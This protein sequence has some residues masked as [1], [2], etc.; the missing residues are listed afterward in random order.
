MIDSILK[1]S[2][3]AKPPTVFHIITGVEVGG[4][5]RMLLR[6]MEHFHKGKFKHIVISLLPP[7]S[8]WHD[9]KD[10][11]I[12]M[13]SLGMKGHFDLLALMRYLIFLMRNKPAIV[14]AYLFHALTFA[15]IGKICF[16]NH[17]LVNYKR[18][19]T[20]ASRFRDTMSR[21]YSFF[22]DYLITISKAVL[23]SES[24][25]KYQINKNA[26]CVYNG[27]E[28][29]G[30]I[31]KKTRKN[32]IVIGTIARL[33]HCKGLPYLV[34]AAERLVARNYKFQFIIVGRG[35]MYEEL[36][37]MISKA[38][39]NDVFELAGEAKNIDPYLKEFDIFVL[40]SL[41][42]GFGNAL[43][44]AM[45]FGIPVIGTNTS[46]IKEIIEDGCNGLLIQPKSARAIEDAIIRLVGDKQLRMRI[47]IEGRNLVEKKFTIQKTVEALELIFGEVIG[48]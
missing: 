48:R 9:F 22:I 2:R 4:A 32:T 39:L 23:A 6:T 40:P 41:Y 20:F 16:P 30:S 35:E 37:K 44:E 42:E 43:I 27:V 25:K 5:E 28:L 26:F 13:V 8:L 15:V 3:K 14:V 47:G 18:S 1:I 21:V 11:D 10:L 19:I 31:E 34:E 29:P 36:A 12:D 24:K 38:N 17:R 7:G 46:G 45:S 33:N